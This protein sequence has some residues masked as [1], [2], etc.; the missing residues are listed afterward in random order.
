MKN[1]CTYLLTYLLTSLPSVDALTLLSCAFANKMPHFHTC[2]DIS[3][4]VK[5]CTVAYIV[6]SKLAQLC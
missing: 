3:C 5:Y 1:R 4:L 2:P 6:D